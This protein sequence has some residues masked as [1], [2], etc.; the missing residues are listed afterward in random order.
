[1]ER[2]KWCFEDLINRINQVGKVY[3]SWSTGVNVSIK[4]GDRVFLIRLG[5]NPRGIVASGYAV[6]NVYVSPHWEI[7]RALVG[8][9]S[10]HIYVKFEKMV[11]IEDSPLKMSVLKELS[12]TFRWSSQASGISIPDEIA[13]KMERRW[14]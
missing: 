6:T 11:N 3:E 12:P 10:K 2:I 4:D 9:K 14:Q 7:N 1:M 13:L 8:D 5:K